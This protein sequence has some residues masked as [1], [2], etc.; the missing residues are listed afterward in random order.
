MGVSFLC[1]GTWHSSGHS[2]ASIVPHCDNFIP[3]LYLML[4]NTLRNQFDKVA[5]RILLSVKFTSTGYP[6]HGDLLVNIGI[7]WD[8]GGH[9]IG[10]GDSLIRS[11]TKRF[12][13]FDIVLFEMR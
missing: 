9:A 11:D 10:D 5:I 7:S 6:N 3:V 1:V 4:L 12:E 13:Y 8:N 2:I